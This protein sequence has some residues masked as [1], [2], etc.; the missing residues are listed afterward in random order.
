MKNESDRCVV[1]IRDNGTEFLNDSKFDK[2]DPASFYYS[3][4]EVRAILE[5]FDGLLWVEPSFGQDGRFRFA[6]P[7]T[8]SQLELV[9][10]RANGHRFA[11]RSSVVDSTVRLE[12][13][14]MQEAN[15]DR[16][17]DIDGMSVPVFSMAELIDSQMSE[18]ESEDRVVIL[19]LADRRIGILMRGEIEHISV[20]PIQISS[21]ENGLIV[22]GILNI[23]DDE[24]PVLDTVDLMNRSEYLRRYEMSLEDVEGFVD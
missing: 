5:R 2:P 1:D 15:R 12:R 7:V 19:G 22:R 13:S 14:W 18:D 8:D 23:D 24:I 16:V 6:V 3:L 9:V 4:R 11:I 10:F 17:L 21:N 20:N